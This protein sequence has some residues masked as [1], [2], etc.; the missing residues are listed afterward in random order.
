[1]D[2]IEA[3]IAEIKNLNLIYIFT[4]DSILKNNTEKY[5]GTKIVYNKDQTITLDY[6]SPY[7][8]KFIQKILSRYNKEKNKR[9]IIL[10][11]DL[12]KKIVQDSFFTIVEEKKD[13]N[14]VSS[15]LVNTKNNKVKGYG[16]YLE[17]VIK[18]I[19]KSIMNYEIVS[20]ESIDGF[21]YKYVVNYSIGN[22]KKQLFLLMFIKDNSIDFKISNIDGK[23]VNISGTIE[24]N[25]NNIELKWCEENNN[26]KGII[27]YDSK[28]KN[29]TEKLYKNEERIISKEYEDTMLEEDEKIISFYINIC[30]LKQLENIM[31]IDD[32]C[33]FLSDN[34]VITEKEGTVYNNISLMIN[35]LDD[36]VIIKQREKSGI[37]KYN[38]EIKAVLEEIIN[39]FTLKKL[40]IDNNFYILIENKTSINDI[41]SYNYKV[42]KLDSD[43]NF[44]EPFDISSENE[45]KKELK[46]FESVKQ[47]IKNMKGGK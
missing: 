8:S 21:N 42:L 5:I 47:Y 24:D 20:I 19:L 32:N 2:L 10:L 26:I 36:E 29:I 40:N 38:D 45:I 23:N 13:F 15:I 3:K 43:K 14:Q 1:M 12:T 33:Y 17:K 25:F 44:F 37:S 16:K 22:I 35:I 18:T 6:K 28:E 46:N 7:F 34:E 30:N 4:T 41:I 31:K 11:G 27:V 9:N 39:E